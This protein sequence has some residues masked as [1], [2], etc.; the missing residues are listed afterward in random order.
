MNSLTRSLFSNTTR[1]LSSNVLARSSTTRFIQYNAGS[2]L[3]RLQDINGNSQQRYTLR[4]YSTTENKTTEQQTSTT[5]AEEKPTTDTPQQPT[6]ED[7]IEDLKKQLEEKHKLLLYTAAERENA[8]KFGKEEADKAKK[9]GIQSFAKELLEVVDQ[10]EMALGQYNQ[11]HLSANN[12]LRTLHEGVKMTEDL[13]LKIMGKNGLIR[14][15]PV[16]EKFDPNSHHALYQI[17]DATVDPGTI[18]VVHKQGYKLNDRLV[19]PAQVGVSK[20]ST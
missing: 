10:L 6:L 12:D 2:S 4:S 7:Q 15:N 19:R 17:E 1:Y 8:R 3:R 9:F 18:K 11:E 16:G 13:F 14:F 5:A 20:K